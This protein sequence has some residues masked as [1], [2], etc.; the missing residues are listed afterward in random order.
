[1]KLF[2]IQHHPSL[3][4]SIRKHEIGVTDSLGFQTDRWAFYRLLGINEI[5]SQKT[6]EIFLGNIAFYNQSLKKT[7]RFACRNAPS[8]DKEIL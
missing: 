5:F 6:I 1:M 3:R 2:V 7:V 4:N 8:E